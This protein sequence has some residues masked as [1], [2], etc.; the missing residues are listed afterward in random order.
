MPLFFRI[1][2]YTRNTEQETN[3]CSEGNDDVVGELLAIDEL[4]RRFQKLKDQ[5]QSSTDTSTTSVNV[6]QDRIE[7]N[8]AELE[9]TNHV[10]NNMNNQKNESGKNSITTY[11][12]HSD[13][14]M[15][16]HRKSITTW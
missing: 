3:V 2:L 12:H 15:I 11:R 10:K 4:H 14:I 9:L 16:N 1:V 8:R 7:Q 5:P 6:E 13:T